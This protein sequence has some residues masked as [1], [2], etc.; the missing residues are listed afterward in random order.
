M[1]YFKAYI[2]HWHAPEGFCGGRGKQ[3]IMVE[4]NMD[5]WH[6][7]VVMDESQ[8]FF[9]GEKEDEGNRINNEKNQFI[10]FY[11]SKL[12]FG[13]YIKRNYHIPFLVHGYASWSTF[14]LHLVRGPKIL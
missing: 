14:G 9:Y 5:P 13:T 10:L 7:N 6:K 4:K 1:T 3:G 12:P 8:W 11:F 2:I